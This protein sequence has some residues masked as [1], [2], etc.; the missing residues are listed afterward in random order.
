MKRIIFQSA[1]NQQREDS[2]GGGGKDKQRA[3]GAERS[4]QSLVPGAINCD[5]GS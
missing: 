3:D 4:I 5:N 1:I 2:G